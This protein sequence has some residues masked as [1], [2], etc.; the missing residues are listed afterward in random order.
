MSNLILRQGDVLI[1]Q[2]DSLPANIK[3]VKREKNN[4]VLAHGEV[5]G[6][7]H[8]IPSRH[9]TLYKT[10]ADQ[11]YMRVTAPVQLKHE[12]HSTV[13][14]PPGNY[15]IRIHKE[16]APGELARNVAD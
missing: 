10:E 6:H 9:A 8:R 1:L 5:T 16:Y 14:I 3:P 2:V 15:Q 11:R 4:V 7:S 13:K 12:E